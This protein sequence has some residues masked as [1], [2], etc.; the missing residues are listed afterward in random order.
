M[1]VRFTKGT[2]FQFL[3]ALRYIKADKPDAAQVP[4]KPV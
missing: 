1:T 4:E 2:R 3:S